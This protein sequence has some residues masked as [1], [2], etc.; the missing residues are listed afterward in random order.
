[1]AFLAPIA[2][3][4]T[5]GAGIASAVSASRQAKKARS[6]LSE[7]APAATP[8]VPKVEDAAVKAK[9]DVKKRRQVLARTGGIT[10]VTRGSAIVPE[11]NI[12]RRSLL[13]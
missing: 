3:I 7:A 1:M 6:A 8:A 12:G 11:A 10:N 2:A 13:G 9:A 4:F 5:A